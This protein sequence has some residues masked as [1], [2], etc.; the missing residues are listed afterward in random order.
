M[1][2][3]ANAPVGLQPDKRSCWVM[4][5]T[6]S[7]LRVGDLGMFDLQN[8]ATETVVLGPGE[9]GVFGSIITPATAGLQT[10]WFGVVDDLGSSAGV[11]NSVVSVCWFGKI[12]AYVEGSDATAITERLTAANGQL[13]LNSDTNTQSKKILGVPLEVSAGTAEQ[14]ITIMFSGI[15]MCF[16]GGGD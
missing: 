14:L 1:F 7:T 3:F 15:F 6:G 9:T 13:Q 12:K 16:G 5:R 4:N 2:P 10:G 8:V 11:D